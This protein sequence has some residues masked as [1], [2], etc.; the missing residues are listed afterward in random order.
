[1][2]NKF[3][4]SI[5]AVILL[6]ISTDAMSQLYLGGS[7]QASV[8]KLKYSWDTNDDDNK[9][10]QYNFGPSIG[11]M[12]S[13]RSM[14]GIEF[15]II[16]YNYTDPDQSQ[17]SILYNFY[18]YFRYSLPISEKISFFSHFY[19]GIGFGNGDMIIDD[20]WAYYKAEI[21]YLDYT[22]GFTPG[23]TF[24]LTNRLDLELTIGSLIYNYQEA[25]FKEDNDTY[26]FHNFN[27]NLNSVGLGLSYTFRK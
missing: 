12:I 27:L 15:S 1:M 11:F 24:A 2:K 7:I 10:T 8:S 6:L 21:D 17:N 9:E 16:S 26:Y 22:V 3:L 23:L 18:P 19:A 20:G 25:T 4:I 5:S 13:E 14:L